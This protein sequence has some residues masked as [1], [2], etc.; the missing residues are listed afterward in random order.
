MDAELI[1]RAR[2]F[3]RA[4]TQRV[5]ALNDHY[6]ARD[7][8]LGEARVLWEIGD[9]GC[10]VRI[11]RTRLGLDS[12]YA[13]RLLRSLESAG[14]VTVTPSPRDARVRT[15]RLT[16]TGKAER[17]LLDR[18]SDA[19]AESMLE[20]LT[21]EERGR[22]VAAMAEV[23]RLL[24]TPVIQIDEI[25]PDDPRARYCLH[26]YFSELDR[27]FHTGFDPAVSRRAGADEMRAPNGS[28]LVAGLRDEPVGCGGLKFHGDE[29]AEIKRMWVAPSARGLG[30][31]RRLLEDLERRAV[32]N[33]C[34]ALQ[35]DTNGSLVEAI[36]MYRS[37]GYR[38]VAAFNDEPY[39]TH[40]F[41]KTI[42]PATARSP[43]PSRRG[44]SRRR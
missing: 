23:E 20:P 9:A 21:P 26:E 30:V 27:R 19:L 8:P 38:E 34:R 25:D 29:P 28:F 4:V 40:W 37:A 13:S 22:L 10:D 42:S 18:R 14:L 16:R 43:S 2:R 15:A 3:N 24:V 17:A 11:L 31:G 41:E 6:L 1:D 12:G 7:R 5:G 36:A 33:G 35:L 32:A 39:A 44:P